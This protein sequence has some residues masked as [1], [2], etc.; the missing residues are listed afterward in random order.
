MSQQKNTSNKKNTDA[1]VDH[2]KKPAEILKTSKADTH[3]NPLRAE[4]SEHPTKEN[5]AV[6][7]SEETR[8]KDNT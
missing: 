8:K 6:R 5:K 4:L 2:S 7:D 1:K 3:T